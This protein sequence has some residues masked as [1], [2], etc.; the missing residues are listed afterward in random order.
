MFLNTPMEYGPCHQDSAQGHSIGAN[1]PV[2]LPDVTPVIR[3]TQKRRA[4]SDIAIGNP[5]VTTDLPMDDIG[6]MI[7]PA[8]V[9]LTQ[10]YTPDRITS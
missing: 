8:S 6:R 3:K 1:L 4:N 7:M 5:F 10:N 9:Y 2:N